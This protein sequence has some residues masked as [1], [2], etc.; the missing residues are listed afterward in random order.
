M[1]HK[2]LLFLFSLL[3]FSYNSWAQK[4][5]SGVVIDGDFNEPLMGAT[6]KVKGTSLGVV[7]DINGR[8]TLN[9]IPNESKF[10]EI[11][12]MGFNPQSVPIQ[13]NIKV[14]LQSE[15]KNLG[16]VVV[17]GMQKMDKRCS[18]VPR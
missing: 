17:T 6:I 2:V 9:N 8:F 16:E 11:T 12:Y 3:A 13:E 1:K 5:A 18:L 4:K 15:K 10:L 7:T 14:I